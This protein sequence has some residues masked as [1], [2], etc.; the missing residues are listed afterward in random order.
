MTSDRVDVS[1]CYGPSS[2]GSC[3]GGCGGMEIA[4]RQGQAGCGGPRRK[5]PTSVMLTGKLLT[6]DN[7][8]GR[9]PSPLAAHPVC[10][11][12]ERPRQLA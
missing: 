10:V 4:K 6:Q 2:V 5:G 11:K 3:V 12:C 1:Q 9:W 7:D 8:S